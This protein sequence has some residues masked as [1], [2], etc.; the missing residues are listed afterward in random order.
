MKF[1]GLLLLMLLLTACGKEATSTA[2]QPAP[3]S[4][5]ATQPAPE[6]AQESAQQFWAKFRTAALAGNNAALQEIALIPFT[7]RG[8]T[9]GD[10]AATHDAAAFAALVPKILAQDTGLSAQPETVL[11]YIERHAE[12]P[13]IATGGGQSKPVPADATEF[14]AGPLVF[15]KIQQRWYWQSAYLEE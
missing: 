15:A 2:A 13:T 9:D 12:L 14:R 1:K 11:Q 8:T 4:T 3:T 7:T 6:A 10:P 5:M